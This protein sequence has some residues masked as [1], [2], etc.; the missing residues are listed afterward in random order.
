LNP[1]LDPEL[2]QVG[3]VVLVPPDPAA[4]SPDGEGSSPSGDYI[5]H[6]VQPGE[7]LLSI[8]EEYEVSIESIRAANDMGPYEDRIQVNQSLVIPISTP[9]PTPPPTR[10]PDATATP[11]PS[12]RPP[13]LLAPSDGAVFVAG[14][15]LVVLQ[16]VAVGLLGPDEWYAVYLGQRGGGIA[17]VAHT[18]RSTGWRVP[19]ELLRAADTDAGEFRWYV[20]VVRQTASPGRAPTYEKAGRPSDTRT[21]ALVNPTT[22]PS[23]PVTATQ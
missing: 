14:D 15:Q 21:F 13:Q 9:T 22:T 11:L 20:Q 5:I 12:Y 10:D 1:D 4:V 18:T 17:S 16:W 23:P 7:A 19:L 8:A 3:Q 2:L 6:I